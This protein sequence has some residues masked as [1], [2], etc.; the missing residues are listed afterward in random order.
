MTYTEIF[1]KIVDVMQ[2]DSATCKDYGA[3]EHDKYREKLSDD[4]DRMEFLHLVQAQ[5][6][7]L[8]CLLTYSVRQ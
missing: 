1:E 5:L 4:M 7:L 2:N 6:V 8:Y 3:G